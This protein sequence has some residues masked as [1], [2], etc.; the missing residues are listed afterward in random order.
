[1]GPTLITRDGWKIRT[2][3]NKEV[4]ELYYLPDDFREE[5]DLAEKYPEKLEELTIIL[6]SACDG[7]L[8]NGLYTSSGKQINVEK[9]FFRYE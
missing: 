5:N 7:D 8:F 6:L 3:L 1:M 9:Q 4:F 2:Y